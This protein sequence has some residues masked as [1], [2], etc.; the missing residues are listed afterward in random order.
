MREPKVPFD[1]R[2]FCQRGRDELPLDYSM[3]PGLCN[4]NPGRLL[5]MVQPY[6]SL[7]RPYSRGRRL[8]VRVA[9]RDVPSLI[10]DLNLLEDWIEQLARKKCHVP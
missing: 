4:W 6:T 7:G 10:S 1:P 2:W 3:P 9:G 8:V 5:W